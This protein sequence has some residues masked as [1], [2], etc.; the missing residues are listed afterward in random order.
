MD[1][2]SEQPSSLQSICHVR[3]CELFPKRNLQVEDAHLSVPFVPVC[4]EGVEFLG[5]TADGILA[6]SN[7]RLHLLLKDTYYSIPLGLIEL[8]EVKDIFYLHVGCKD[9]RSL[10]CTFTTNEH[11]LDWF[12][13]LHKATMS[14]CNIEDLFAFAF[15]AWS[16][17]EGG[18]EVAA[19]L[20]GSRDALSGVSSFRAEV[21]RLKFDVHGAWRISQANSDYRLCSSY[22]RLLLVPACISDETLESAAR[23]RSA[24]RVPAVVWRHT[25]NGAVIARCSQPEVG[26]LGWRSSEDEDLLKAIADACAYDRGRCTMMD[27]GNT[28]TPTRE[29]TENDTDSSNS[30]KKVLIMDAR[31]YTTAVANRARG[32]GCECPEYY[33]SCEIQFMNLANIHSIRKSFHAVRQL[34][35]STA[36]QANWFSLL[37]G[38]RWLQHMSGLLRAAVTVAS[39]IEHEGRPV[40]VHC[41]DGWDRTPQIVALA[42]LLLD[43]YYRTIDGFQVLCER[44][45]L[46]FGH[47]F[48]DRCGHAV[49]GDDPNERCPVFLQWLDCVHQLLYQFPCS[50][51]FSLAYLV[52]LAQH[53]YSNLFGTFLCNSTQERT[54]LKVAERTF[55]VWKFLK[56]PNFRNHLYYTPRE[57][58]LWPSCNV[59]DLVLWSEVYLGA[60][61]SSH[62][63]SPSVGASVAQQGPGATLNGEHSTAHHNGTSSSPAPVGKTRSYDDL[64]AAADHATQMHRRS[65]DPSIALDSKFDGLNLA[66]HDDEESV[67]GSP[68]RLIPPAEPSPL[69][70]NSR[71]VPIESFSSVPNYHS[72]SD[73]GIGDPKIAD[74]SEDDDN[75]D[76]TTESRSETTIC[77]AAT[78]VNTASVPQSVDSSTD[79][80]VAG[81]ANSC[82]G[83]MKAADGVVMAEEVNGVVQPILLPGRLVGSPTVEYPGGDVCRVCASS[84][85]FLAD[86]GSRADGSASSSTSGKTSRY[87]TP[88]LYSRTPSSGYPATPSDER[89]PRHHTSSITSQRPDD[90]DGLAPLHNEVQMRLQHIIAEHRAKEDA[91]QRELHTTRLALIQQVCHHCSH[92]NAERPDDVGSLPESVCS[93]EQPSAGESLPSDVS[94]EAVEERETGPTLWVPDHA[95]N[96]C[97]GCDTEFWLGRRRHHCRNCGK[98]FCADCSE[99]TVPLPNEQLYDPVRVCSSCYAL[100]HNASTL[101]KRQQ[102]NGTGS[103]NGFI[104]DMDPPKPLPLSMMNGSIDNCKQQGAEVKCPKPVVTAAS[105]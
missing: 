54:S 22:P 90:L 78:T 82:N 24:R 95:V 14:P 98:I 84:R 53:T 70:N 26:W 47:K 39:A 63:L 8:I 18:E 72:S 40:L 74:D 41:S 51:E 13:R 86:N 45:W 94:W 64:L 31:S 83:V 50:F 103:T 34:C 48:A 19:R 71:H 101:L 55:S 65:S 9:A 104:M 46:D 3:A 100:L 73:E 5:R 56:A 7:Y 97:M 79:T 10:R 92:T 28:G 69:E 44:E 75:E 88:P 93:G 62:S 32:G 99:N 57:P 35:S 67:E 105:T 29:A 96:R 89:A 60:V 37:E 30:S 21:E 12:R 4:G 102:M 80:L 91:L 87:S 68:D 61:E 33:P 59:R 58:V 85:R 16:S 38:T 2:S 25:G 77:A 23:F 42:E 76:T 52:K 1:G 36:E 49:G 15:M 43:P 6:L 27:R 81:D 20:G 17:E 66:V 11:C